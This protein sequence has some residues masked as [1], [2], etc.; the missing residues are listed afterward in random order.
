MTLEDSVGFESGRGPVDERAAGPPSES[1][2]FRYHGEGSEFFILLLKNVFLTLITLG[3]Y[4][5]WAKTARRKYIWGHIDLH[6]QRLMY[7][8]TGAE[9]FAGY[10]KVAMAY[11][12]IVGVPSVVGHLGGKGAQ[13][14]VQGALGIAVLILVP[15]AIFWSRAY[16]LSRTSWRGIRL[17]MVGSAGPYAR[18]FIVGYLLTLVTL[19]LYAPFWLNHL[20][21]LMTGATRLGSEPFAYDGRGG[22]LFKLYVKGV[23]LTILTLG[24]YWFWMQASVQRYYFSHTAFSGARGSFRLRGGQLLK[25]F[26]LNLFGTTLTLGI[27][28]PWIATYSLKLFMEHVSFEG[29]I[30]FAAVLQGSGGASP[31]S[32]VLADALGVDLGL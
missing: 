10:L 6:G 22:E 2:R 9:L 1:Y 12:I 24:I 25:L 5:A 31:T 3:I 14:V 17:G 18:A 32:D 7:T 8:G 13:L 30:D 15:Y 19:G 11:L 27:A 29:R 23:L 16:L 28:F 26:L 4:A 21:T 20:R